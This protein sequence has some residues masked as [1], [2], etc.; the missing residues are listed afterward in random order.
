VH[1]KLEQKIGGEMTNFLKN[2]LYTLIDLAYRLRNKLRR[3]FRLLNTT[4]EVTERSDS[5]KTFYLAAVDQILTNP[6]IFARFRGIHDY[7][8]I[9][10]HVNYKLGKKYLDKI[11]SATAEI[12]HLLP[13]FKKNDL[14]GNPRRY[15]YKSF[16]LISPTTL[17]YISVAVEIKNLF[18]SH[19]D[20]VVEIGGGYGGQASIL[21]KMNFYESYE[22]YDLPEVQELARRFLTL[23]DIADV[24]F[25]GLSNSK[26]SRYDLVISNYAFSELPRQ[27]QEKYIFEILLNSDRGFL[28]MNSGR[29][30]KSG[31]STGKVS[32]EE[33]RGL[34][35]Y[36]EVLEETPKTG[37]DNYLIVWS[38]V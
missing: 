36:I 31:R 33:I 26:S 14:V 8:E 13:S 15:K 4:Q 10:E 22:I 19:L 28:I 32:I 21:S 7:R 35:P 6:E 11:Q 2:I 30:N 24:T 18:G 1:S 38:R 17:R 37:P 5:E 3:G 25:P 20:K 12:N 27:L 34:L 16:G 29:S 9:L 23:Q